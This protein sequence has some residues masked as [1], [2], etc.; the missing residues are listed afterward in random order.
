MGGRSRN[1]RRSDPGRIVYSWRSMRADHVVHVAQVATHPR[2]YCIH[3]KCE[4]ICIL[5]KI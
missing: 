3:V 5:S 4:R 1:Q 2:W